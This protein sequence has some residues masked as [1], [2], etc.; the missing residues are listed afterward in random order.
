[1][2]EIYCIFNNETNEYLTALVQGEQ[3]DERGDERWQERM[4]SLNTLF[5]TPH[6]EDDWILTDEEDFQKYM[7]GHSG[8][9]IRDPQTNHAVKSPTA[10]YTFDEKIAQVQSKYNAKLKELN[11]SYVNASLADMDTTNLKEQYAALVEE[12]NTEFMQV[13]ENAG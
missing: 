4:A 6:T 5:N 8:G 10:G 9:Y 13:I 1:M 3:F 12:S 2:R 11:E 7:L